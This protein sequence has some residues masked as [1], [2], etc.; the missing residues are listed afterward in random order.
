M[1]LHREGLVQACSPGL[2]IPCFSRIDF[3]AQAAPADDEEF[4]VRWRE[5]RRTLA[6]NNT[7]AD[8]EEH[9]G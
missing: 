6:R 3:T 7:V 1:K 4:S 8:D 9:S 5:M 2:H